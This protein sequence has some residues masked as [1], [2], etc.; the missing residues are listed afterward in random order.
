MTVM[1]KAAG[2]LRRDELDPRRLPCGEHNT[3]VFE[4]IRDDMLIKLDGWAAVPVSQEI[5]ST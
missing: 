3:L 2:G 5:R 1:I 4:G